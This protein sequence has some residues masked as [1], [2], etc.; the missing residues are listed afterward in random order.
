MNSRPNIVLDFDRSASS[1]F[2]LEW[3]LNLIG[4]IVAHKFNP[5]HILELG[6]LD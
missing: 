6:E 5:L 3:G 4:I 1:V 2:A